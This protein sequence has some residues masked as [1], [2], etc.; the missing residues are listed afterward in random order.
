M[1]T[2]QPPPSKDV[3]REVLSWIAVLCIVVVM[4]AIIAFAFTIHVRA[5]IVAIGLCAGW[6]AVVIADVLKKN[7]P[8]KP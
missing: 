2:E 6:I 7:P 1:N 3:E 5:G 8:P 4:G